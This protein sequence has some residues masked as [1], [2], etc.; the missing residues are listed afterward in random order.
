[1]GIYSKWSELVGRVSH[2]G[3]TGV[4]AHH[5]Y[6]YLR[7]EDL[8]NAIRPVMYELGLVFYPS[9]ISIVPGNSTSTLLTAIC[10]YT[11]V[12]SETGESVNI[13]VVSQGTD[14]GDKS[15]FKLMT[16]ARKYSL[17][18]LI[19]AGTGDDPE[20]DTDSNERG[21]LNTNTIPVIRKLVANGFFTHPDIERDSNYALLEKEI[22]IGLKKFPNTD[23]GT[24]ALRHVFALAVAF[25][26]DPSKEDALIRVCSDSVKQELYGKP[27]A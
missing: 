6:E 8:L 5:K 25:G 20:E 4:N 9:K 10:T 17:R 21:V 1:M 24:S 27:A 14:S 13:E 2:L 19:L 11:L 26:K 18:Q 7:E 3:M 16:G 22:G 12:D 15:A 23:K